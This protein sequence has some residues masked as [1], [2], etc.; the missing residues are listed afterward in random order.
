MSVV[1]AVEVVGCV[2]GHAGAVDV[3]G[4]AVGPKG[5]V[6]SG[7]VEVEDGGMEGFGRG[8]GLVE[9]DG[10]AVT[11]DGGVHGARGRL[12]CVRGSLAGHLSG[13]QEEVERTNMKCVNHDP[14][15]VVPFTEV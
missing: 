11:L 14:E 13:I 6:A 5:G 9:A 2:E 4:K 15:A 10:C 3:G 12:E 1:G 7:S 8:L